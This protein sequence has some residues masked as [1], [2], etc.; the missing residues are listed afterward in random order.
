MGLAQRLSELN[1]HTALGERFFRWAPT[2]LGALGLGGVSGWAAWATKPLSEYSPISWVGSGLLGVLLFV[3]VY[4]LWTSAK[5]KSEQSKNAEEMRARARWVN[6]LESVFTNQRIDI[7]IFKSPAPDSATGKTF[8]NCDI[9]GPATVILN[10]HTT[11]D[12]GHF[13][14]CDF[15]EVQ[16]GCSIYNAVSVTDTTFR[17]CRIFYVTF[18]SK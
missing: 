4:W 9:Y 3:V 17:N 1:T 11:L 18:Y 14:F 7:D 5:L 15:V 2:I 8:V 16:A 10:G 13:G 12:D 6:P